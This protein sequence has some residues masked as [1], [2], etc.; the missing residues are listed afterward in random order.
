MVKEK[1]NVA[2][3]STRKGPSINR[4][5]EWNCCLSCSMC[6]RFI[7]RMTQNSKYGCCSNPKML[8]IYDPDVTVCETWQPVYKGD[9]IITGSSAFNFNDP[10][11]D[12]FVRL[13]LDAINIVEKEF[14]HTDKI[15]PVSIHITDGIEDL[16]NIQFRSIG[17]D[18]KGM[19][20]VEHMKCFL[21]NNIFINMK[22]LMSHRRSTIYKTST[23]EL[24]AGFLHEMIHLVKND[25]FSERQ[26]VRKEFRLISKYYRGEA[27]RVEYKK[28]LS[29]VDQIQEAS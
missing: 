23:T 9:I 19:V 1:F 20:A 2:Y 5:I 18:N 24:I 4:G 6:S 13:I 15:Y 8:E 26:V 14:K 16:S 28:Y 27:N 17:I 25:V 11:F 21:P 12:S 3:Y 10:S 22:N 29:K 7:N